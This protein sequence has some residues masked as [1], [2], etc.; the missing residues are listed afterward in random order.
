MSLFQGFDLHRI[1][2]TYVVLPKGT[3]RLSGPSL[4][5]IARQISTSRTP[6]PARAPGSRTGEQRVL[7]A[8]GA[9][10]NPS[11]SCRGMF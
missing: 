9:T 1:G 10:A 6:R 7:V 3:P 8:V 4:S 2:G 11:A 5:A